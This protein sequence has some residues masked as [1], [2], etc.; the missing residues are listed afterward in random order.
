M[1]KLQK[2]DII[3]VVAPSAP[4][5]AFCPRRLERGVEMLKKM[6]YKVKLGKTVT[7]VEDYTAGT[8][9][10]RVEDIHEMFTDPKVKLIMATIG[11]Y[12]ANDLLEHLDY[13]LIRKNQDKLFIGYSDISILLLALYTKS[14][15]QTVMGPMVLPQFGEYPEIQRFTQDSF[16]YVTGNIGSGLAYE[17]PIS[18]EW[19]EEML[20]WD[21]E[22]DRARKMKENSGWEMIADGAA[23]GRLLAGNISTIAKMIGTGYLP[24]T[25]GAIL[26]LEDDDEASLSVIQGLMQ[27]FRQAGLM[28]G[29]QGLVFGRFQKGSE[30]ES[31]QLEKMLVNILGSFNIPVIANVDFGHTDPLL[32]LPLGKNVKISTKEGYIRIVL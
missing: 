20:S 14:G 1:P 12:N 5:S 29:I 25:E 17:L 11:G 27:Q 15:V 18:S 4:I 26:F 16:E 13:E 31:G 9:S 32:S 7:M 19:T 30:I 2:G 22:D 23:E 24:E 6:G 8:I 21:E 10:E 28:K 3:G